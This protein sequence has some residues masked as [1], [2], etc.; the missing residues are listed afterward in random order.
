[1]GGDTLNQEGSGLR[2][3]DTAVG[4]APPGNKVMLCVKQR[5]SFL[6]VACLFLLSSR[7]MLTDGLIY[8]KQEFEGFLFWR[9]TN[10]REK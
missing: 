6:P 8:P 4:R 3:A 2:D 7:K 5:E 1:M 10:P 9:L